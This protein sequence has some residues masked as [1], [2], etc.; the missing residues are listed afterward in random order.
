[1]SVRVIGML[2]NT[3]A[4]SGFF[5][6]GKMQK[7]TDKRTPWLCDPTYLYIDL[8]S[9]LARHDWQRSEHLEPAPIFSGM[10]CVPQG[11]VLI[12]GAREIFSAL[13][14]LVN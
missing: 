14:L 13:T 6:T 4:V 1:M 9:G 2:V 11:Q 12:S 3:R 10:I 5:V 8:L 7:A